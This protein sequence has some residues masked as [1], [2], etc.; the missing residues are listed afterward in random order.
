M[1][2]NK[3]L[4]R[5]EGES[6]LRRAVRRT[7]EAGLEPALV[8]LGHDADRA[9]AELAGLSCRPVMNLEYARGMGSSLRAGI[10]AVPPGAIAA[11]VALADMPLVTA[12]MMA[13]LALRYRRGSAPLVASEYGG[14]LAPPMLYDR[15]LFRELLVDHGN[16]GH[17]C[18]KHVVK[19]HEAEA[20]FVPWP[21][22]T[23][24]D[25]DVPTDY[26]RIQAELGG[27]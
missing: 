13:E 10:A 14:V 6:V 9:R 23:L 18:G 19:R 20:I 7:L 17:G 4:L 26:Q 22:A 15:A 27:R 11:V 1:G 3:L 24:T 12:A 2:T 5:L 16:G 8:V 25:L 21:A